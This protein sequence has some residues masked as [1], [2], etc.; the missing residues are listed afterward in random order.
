MDVP[1]DY[2]V[3]V[4]EEELTEADHMM[5]AV[6]LHGKTAWGSMSAPSIRKLFVNRTGLLKMDPYQWSLQVER[7]DEDILLGKVPWGFQ[8]VRFSWLEKTISVE[9]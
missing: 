8:H 7:K 6:C 1:L 9:W 3:E 2:E 5:E 4:I